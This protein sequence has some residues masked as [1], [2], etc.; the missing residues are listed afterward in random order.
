MDDVEADCARLRAG[1]LRVLWDRPRAGTRGSRVN[2]VHP[3]DAG[4]VLVELVQRVGHDA[5]P[6]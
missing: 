5:V 1:G 4:G 3:A 6:S 2:F